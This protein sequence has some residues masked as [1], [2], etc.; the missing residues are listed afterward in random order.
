MLVCETS[1]VGKTLDS[2]SMSMID[3]VLFDLGF[4]PYV[5][6]SLPLVDLSALTLTK[7][8]VFVMWPFYVARGCNTEELEQVWNATTIFEPSHEQTFRFVEN[9]CT[10]GEVY[11]FMHATLL[12]FVVLFAG[13]KR[14]GLV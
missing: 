10:V 5:K 2:V 4:A 3:Y 9:Y 8:W 11:R 14:L 12:A 7:I 6:S 1:V 13:A